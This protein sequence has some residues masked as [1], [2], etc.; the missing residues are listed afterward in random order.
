ML[1][2][3]I[4]A[5]AGITAGRLAAVAAVPRNSVYLM[6]NP[7]RDVLPTK[8]D[9]V[10]NVAIACGLPPNQVEKVMTIWVTL[11]NSPGSTNADESVA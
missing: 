3:T 11:R 2:D 10:R 6:L 1:L 4:R 5:N 9:N 7:E 8:P